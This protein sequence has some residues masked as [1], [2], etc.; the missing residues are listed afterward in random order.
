MVESKLEI[1][2]SRAESIS[3]IQP[4]LSRRF[5]SEK[6]DVI[7]SITPKYKFKTE[8]SVSR[9]ISEENESKMCRI[10]AYK[11]SVFIHK[12]NFCSLE[13]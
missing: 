11:N 9:C 6:M 13:R 5:T 2:K 7:R 8:G 12:L 10:L 3:K 4:T 1:G